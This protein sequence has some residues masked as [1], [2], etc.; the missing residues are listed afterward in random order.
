MYAKFEP[1]T[2]VHTDYRTTKTEVSKNIKKR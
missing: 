2:Y 1:Y